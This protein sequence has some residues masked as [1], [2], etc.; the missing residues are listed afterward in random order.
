MS[1]GEDVSG[2]NFIIGHWQ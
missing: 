1:P 2:G